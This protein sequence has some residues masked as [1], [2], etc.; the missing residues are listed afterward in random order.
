MSL[1]LLRLAATSEYNTLC[2]WARHSSAC[3]G[4]CRLAHHRFPDAL[5]A[6]IE[7]TGTEEVV[8]VGHSFGGVTITVA[9][10]AT[11]KEGVLIENSNAVAA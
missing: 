6:D 2:T 3:Q 7:S 5:V 4:A 1:R 9:A 11:F 10:S 8:L